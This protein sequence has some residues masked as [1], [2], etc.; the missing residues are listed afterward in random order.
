MISLNPSFVVDKTNVDTA[1]RRNLIRH[2]VLPPL[3]EI[4]ERIEQKA[5]DMCAHLREDMQFLFDE[6]KQYVNGELLPGV[7]GGIASLPAGGEKGQALMKQSSA[8]GD[9]AWQ[10]PPSGGGGGSGLRG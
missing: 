5:T 8:D 3:R 2:K 9:V 4:N 7:G 6:L 10:Y 1:Y